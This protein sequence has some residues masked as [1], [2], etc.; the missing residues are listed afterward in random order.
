M[1]YKALMVS[2]AMFA[3]PSMAQSAPE[4]TN[5]ELYNQ[6]IGMYGRELCDEYV[7]EGQQSNQDKTVTRDQQSN[8]ADRTAQSLK[9]KLGAKDIQRAV[10]TYKQ[11]EL[12][13]VRDFKGKPIAFN[14]VFN[15]VSAENWFGHGHRVSIG[16]GSFSDGVD[17][18]ISDQATLDKIVEWNKGQK[19]YV[20]GIVD[21]VSV[22]DLKL[23]QCKI[24]AVK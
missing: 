13:F 12:R 17:C 8:I 9:E 14:W 7:P 11:N 20:T 10:D 15:S 22:G 16:N 18:Y 19:V 23:S 5:R 2:A 1:N 24:N 21:D 3:V 6:C 4:L